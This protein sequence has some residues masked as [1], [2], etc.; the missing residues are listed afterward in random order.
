LTE[1]PL[2]SI[3]PPTDDRLFKLLM[4]SPELLPGLADIVASIIGQPVRK[5]A[6]R[7]NEL[8]TDDMDD[9]QE[10]LDVNCVTDDGRQVNLEMQA[11]RM[12]ELPG[13]QH[14]N[15]K[16][17]S[18]YYLCDLFSTQMRTYLAKMQSSHW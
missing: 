12:A 5:V 4:T 10:R 9:K 14:E 17:K 13:G 15:L 3:L 8:P 11:S 6:V 16:N 1:P 7:N 18:V 2:K